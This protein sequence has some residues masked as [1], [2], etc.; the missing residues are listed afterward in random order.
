MVFEP[1]KRER[2][3]GSENVWGEMRRE[4]LPPP[5][6]PVPKLAP[7]P[8]TNTCFVLGR[9]GRTWENGILL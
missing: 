5:Y 4:R 8:N 9:G 7:L 1:R 3:R 6:P 2:G